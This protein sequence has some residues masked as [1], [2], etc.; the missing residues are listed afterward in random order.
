MAQQSA[1]SG[2]ERT[3]SLVST[4]TAYVQPLLNVVPTTMF[5][6]AVAYA[7]GFLQMHFLW[8]MII[9]YFVIRRNQRQSRETKRWETMLHLQRLK[10]MKFDPKL[11]PNRHE[12]CQWLNSLVKHAYPFLGPTL[13]SQITASIEETIKASQTTLKEHGVEQLMVRQIDMGTTPLFFDEVKGIILEDGT[14]VRD[15][16]RLVM[17]SITLCSNSK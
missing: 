17:F 10:S 8:V 6:L 14:Y 3:L 15:Q 7:I 4:Y 13:A 12:T 16:R 11:F 1:A 5:G 2:V 9:C